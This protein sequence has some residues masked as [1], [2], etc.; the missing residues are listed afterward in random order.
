MS[1]IKSSKKFSLT[2]S[3]S[4]H[5]SII[6]AKISRKIKTVVPQPYNYSFITLVVLFSQIIK[7]SRES[8]HFFKIFSPTVLLGYAIISKPRSQY[9]SISNDGENL[10]R[11]LGGISIYNSYTYLVR[12]NA[13]QDSTNKQLLT[14]CAKIRE[15]A[16]CLP[17]T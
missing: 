6:S 14:L 4:M 7:K 2:K 11:S 15:A 12:L 16:Y 9:Y 8:I 10:M 1:Q 3:I 13:I 17:Y 5:K